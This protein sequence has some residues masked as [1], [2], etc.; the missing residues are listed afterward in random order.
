LFDE[1]E[2]MEEVEE[3]EEQ[4]EEEEEEEEE[5]DEEEDEDTSANTNEY[6]DEP[7]SATCDLEDSHAFNHCG[8]TSFTLSKSM[9]SV[10]SLLKRPSGVM[11]GSESMRRMCVS[12]ESAFSDD[13]DFSLSSLTNP[14]SLTIRS[15]KMERCLSPTFSPVML[16][17]VPKR[18][19]VFFGEDMVGLKQTR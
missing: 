6:A 19:R 12:S 3:G 16:N 14:P 13:F 15:L 5:E 8:L 17:R 18:G 10:L 9:R 1:D 2:V 11:D 4:D 7:V